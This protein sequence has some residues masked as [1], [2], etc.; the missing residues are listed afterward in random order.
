LNA[1]FCRLLHSADL[2]AGDR[3]I[4][5]WRVVTLPCNWDDQPIGTKISGY[6]EKA[7]RV[8]NRMEAE[9]TSACTT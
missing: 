5:F 2:A 1:A 3:I 6:R 8:I 4:A 9:R 7:I